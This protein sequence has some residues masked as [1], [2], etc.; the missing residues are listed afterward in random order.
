MAHISE[1]HTKYV[2]T[3]NGQNSKGAPNFWLE[4]PGECWIPPF[5]GHSDCSGSGNE[6]TQS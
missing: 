1:H 6:L 3:Y 5:C 4:A 2:H